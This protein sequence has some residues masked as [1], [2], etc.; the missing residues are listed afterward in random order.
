MTAEVLKQAA[1]QVRCGGCSSAFNALEFLSEEL[2]LQRP[3]P[4]SGQPAPELTAES[5]NEDNDL[6]KSISAEQSAALL[7]TL[8]QLA[9]SDIRIEDTGVEWRVLDED[10]VADNAAHNDDEKGAADQSFDVS[11]EDSDASF[12]ERR[13]NGEPSDF[14]K[15]LTSTS[16]DE[17]RFDDNTP[18]PD[19]FEYNDAE[20]YAPLASDEDE[21]TEAEPAADIEDCVEQKA[22]IALSEPDEWTDILGEFDEPAEEAPAPAEAAEGDDGTAD[23]ATEATELA[24]DNDDLQDIDTQFDLQAAAMGID[25]SG[26]HDL[27]ADATDDDKA[28]LLAEEGSSAESVDVIEEDSADDGSEIL[29]DDDFEEEVAE[30]DLSGPQQ[31][32]AVEHHTIEEE[33]AALVELEHETLEQDEQ[34]PDEEAPDDVE[35]EQAFLQDEAPDE[36]NDI[37]LPELSEEEQTINR[38]IDQDLMA[39]A[40]EDKDGFAS[41][42]IFPE[43]AAKRVWEEARS[44]A[45][46][47]SITDTTEFESI[48]MEGDTARST[49]DEEKFGRDSAAAAELANLLQAQAAETESASG[50]VRRG[51]VAACIVLVLVLIVQV[52][53]QSREALA[54]IPAF[55]NTIGPIYRALGRPLQ[56]EWDI[57]GWRFEATKGSA[58]SSNEGPNGAT[59]FEGVG[60]ADENLTVYSRIGNKSEQPLPYPLIGI[61]LTDRFEE[62]I[63]SR[64]L[65]PAE[66][67]SNDLDPRKLVRPGN[68]FNA[69]ISIQT[70][71]ENATGF[72]LNVCY[73]LSDG[74]LRCAIDD[75][76]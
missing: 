11:F 34:N 38:M 26:E 76:K 29:L 32:P 18:L 56:P 48:V 55:N 25:I 28:P 46:M 52:V 50:G 13:S 53:H 36:T 44:D 69:V 66:Y 23:K 31:E 70:P 39:L 54:T 41:T 1:G 27:D 16:V 19:D 59:Q 47:Q 2:P 14:E 20:P 58:Q 42:I 12:V 49:D 65:D 60:P 40:I 37:E 64:I 5:A 21:A 72:K 71:S 9:G 75:F 10:E 45:A 6:P 17:I 57:T 3:A 63:G 7:K 68:S 4:T 74:Q 22:D 43:D 62:T 30:L 15:E 24:S 67:L 61:S 8:D 51:V 35:T 33:L 73:R